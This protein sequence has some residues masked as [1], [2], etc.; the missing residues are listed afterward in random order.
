ML[1]PALHA[2]SDLANPRVSHIAGAEISRHEINEGLP[3]FVAPDILRL[4][5]ESQRI[6]DGDE[7]GPYLTLRYANDA[8]HQ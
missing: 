8:Q 2:P 6:G 7:A 5:Y 1:A 4:Q 3:L